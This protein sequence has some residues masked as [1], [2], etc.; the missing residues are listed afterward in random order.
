LDDL[1][2]RHLGHAALVASKLVQRDEMAGGG[3]LQFAGFGKCGQRVISLGLLQ[4]RCAQEM[5]RLAVVLVRGR[6]L[7]QTLGGGGEL[8]IAIETAAAIGRAV[9]IGLDGRLIRLAL[10]VGTATHLGVE[11]AALERRLDAIVSGAGRGHG[12]RPDVI[13]GR[14]AP[15]P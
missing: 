4:Q 11:R 8:S 2:Q 9:G 7:R 10:L 3:V 6:R 14:I 15:P 12:R 13:Q 5:P 1:V